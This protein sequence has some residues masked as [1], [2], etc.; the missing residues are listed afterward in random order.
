MLDIY[1]LYPLIQNAV[2]IF[3]L[4]LKESFAIGGG[5]GMGGAVCV[6]TVFIC[7]PAR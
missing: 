2:P 5:G 6:C 7:A 4:G 3:K 1:V